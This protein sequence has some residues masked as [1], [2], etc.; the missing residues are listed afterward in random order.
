MGKR[1]TILDAGRRGEGEH[2]ATFGRIPGA[3]EKRDNVQP[4]GRAIE[5]IIKYRKRD[6]T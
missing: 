5:Q 2:A 1:W 3:K 4:F 6:A